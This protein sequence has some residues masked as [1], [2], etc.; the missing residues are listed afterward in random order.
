MECPSNDA[1]DGP[2]RPARPRV[3]SHNE[4]LDHDACVRPVEPVSCCAAQVTSGSAGSVDLASSTALAAQP[5][6]RQ[7]ESDGAGS[8]L[9][10]RRAKRSGPSATRRPPVNA[11]RSETDR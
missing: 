3:S 8:V 11:P 10:Q 5:N 9:R 1:E 7:H 6:R 2:G 4:R